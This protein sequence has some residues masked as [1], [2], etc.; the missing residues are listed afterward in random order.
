MSHVGRHNNVWSTHARVVVFGWTFLFASVACNHVV[1]VGRDR[2]LDANVDPIDAHADVALDVSSSDT[3]DAILEDHTHV[4]QAAADVGGDAS[5]GAPGTTFFKAEETS[6][7]FGNSIAVSQLT[8]GIGQVL[9]VGASGRV[10]T[11]WRGSIHGPWSFLQEL[12]TGGDDQSDAFGASIAMNVDGTRVVVGAP[13]EDTQG[14]AI[15]A[16]RNENA[17]DSGA[18]YVFDM[19][20]ERTYSRRTFVKAFN[21]DADDHFGRSVAISGD[22]LRIVVGAP[23]EDGNAVV[24]D[25]TYNN[26]G[27]DVGAVYLYEYVGGQLRAG[28]YLKYHDAPRSMRL[29]GSV[30]ISEEGYTVVGCSSES[31]IT[32]PVVWRF[33]TPRWSSEIGVESYPRQS[34]SVPIAI[35]SEGNFFALGLPNARADIQGGS[36][37]QNAGRVYVYTRNSSGTTLWPVT[38]QLQ[39]DNPHDGDAWGASIAFSDDE[40]ELFVGAPGEDSGTAGINPVPDRRAVDSGALYILRLVARNTWHEVYFVKAP[41]PGVND[42]FGRRLSASSGI[43]VAAPYEAS[44]PAG[45]GSPFN[46]NIPNAGA[47]YGFTYPF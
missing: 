4:D 26:A 42:Q 9:A 31:D 1:S 16:P 12:T 3:R 33:S 32:T 6:E 23:N 29:G 15:N 17:I 44:T 20:T 13:L 35:S 40:S 38:Q 28:H 25:G 39:A 43:F 11:F 2:T 10:W 19:G 8:A 5:G 34:V 18:V 47:V 41:N 14:I 45:V 27:V 46:D 24:I 22:G 7:Q 37:V 36:P 21:V 30:A